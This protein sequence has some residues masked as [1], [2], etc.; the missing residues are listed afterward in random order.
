MNICFESSTAG[1]GQSR[2]LTV[3]SPEDMNGTDLLLEPVSHPAVGPY[4]QAIVAGGMPATMFGVK[5]VQK[6]FDQLTSLEVRFT[7][8]LVKMGPVTTAVLDDTCGNRIQIAQN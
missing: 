4:K 1:L 3:V 7:Q 2:W 5:D 6:E 8:P